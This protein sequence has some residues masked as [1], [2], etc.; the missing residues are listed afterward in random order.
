MNTRKVLRTSNRHVAHIADTRS[1]CTD[2]LETYEIVEGGKKYVI[3][4][5]DAFKAMGALITLEADSM[6]ALEVRM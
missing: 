6:S 5:V 4:K 3:R 2:C 1:T